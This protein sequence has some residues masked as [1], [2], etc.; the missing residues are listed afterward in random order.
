M[1]LASVDK[2]AKDIK[3]VKNLL[4]RQDLFDR[5]VD[6]KRLKTK[7]S[8]EIFRAFLSMITKTCRPKFFGWA[9]EQNL[10][11]I[12]KNYAKLKEYKFTLQ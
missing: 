9:R 11:E 10:L 7:D 8:K 6:A 1:E 2:L 4:V 12:F 3:G 5:I